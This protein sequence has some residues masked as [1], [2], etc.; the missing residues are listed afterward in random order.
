MISFLLPNSGFR[1]WLSV[2]KWVLVIC[3]NNSLCTLL[4]LGKSSCFSNIGNI[5]SLISCVYTMLKSLEPFNCVHT[6]KT[7]MG[8]LLPIFVFSNWLSVFK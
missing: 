7:L 4:L 2:F 1:N 5:K 3:D 6:R 8:F